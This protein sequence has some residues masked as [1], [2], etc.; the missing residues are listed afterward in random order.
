M[1]AAPVLSGSENSQR[2]LRDADRKLSDEGLGALPRVSES[3][4]PETVS[5]AS[6]HRVGNDVQ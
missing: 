5:Q 3:G 2:R 1:A 6:V 4:K